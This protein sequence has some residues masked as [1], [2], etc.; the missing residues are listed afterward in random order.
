MHHYL[1]D[2]ATKIIARKKSLGEVGD[3]E[4]AHQPPLGDDGAESIERA[5]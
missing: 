2:R 5:M 1:I 4:D 3:F